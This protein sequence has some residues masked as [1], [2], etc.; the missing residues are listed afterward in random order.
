MGV[1]P[2]A[3]ATRLLRDK[4]AEQ[5]RRRLPV[6]GI[7]ATLTNQA[8]CIAAG[9]DAWQGRAAFAD[10]QGTSNGGRHMVPLYGKFDRLLAQG[11]K[12]E[13]R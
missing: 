8:A 13:T 11:L 9:M 10:F 1:G 5:G 2:G 12:F 6:I 3:T 7:C 4:E